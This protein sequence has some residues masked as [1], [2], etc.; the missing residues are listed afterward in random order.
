M[1]LSPLPIVAVVAMLTTPGGREN[2][3]A[4]V[5]GWVLGLVAAGTVVLLLSGGAGASEGGAP[6]DWV[7][8]LKLVL[9]FLLLWVA[10]RRWRGRR[11]SGARSELPGW[12]RALDRVT[13]RRATAL[14][15]ALS[16]ANPKN[17]LLT[18]AASTA[19]AQ[20]G[21]TGGSQALALALFVAIATLG[22]ALP[23]AIYA[24]AGERA[25]TLLEELRE[26]MATHNAAIIAVLCV[27]IAAK[28]L[29][30]GLSG[31]SA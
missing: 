10:A 7:S 21:A 13:T 9:G 1:A 6:A 20:T 18:V 31:L 2:G 19:I 29:G 4:F 24:T 16:A 3:V 17:L 5:L 12:M 25:T 22:P 28:L 26:W 15:A 30:D 14:G 23:L 27:V 11:L 8:V